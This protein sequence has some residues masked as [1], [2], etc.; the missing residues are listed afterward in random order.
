[1]GFSYLNGKSWAEVTREERFFCQHLFS[2]LK[3]TGTTT[4]LEYVNHKVGISLPVDVAWEPAFE[5]CF[6]R[7]LRH[8]NGRSG[9]LHSAKRTFDLCLFSERAI[10]IIEAK[11]QQSFDGEQ[12][13]SFAAD[14]DEVKALTG[15]ATYVVGLASSAC[16]ATPGC[17][18]VFEGPL[19]TWRDLAALYDEDATLLRAD[20]IYDP[21]ERDTWGRNNQGGHVTG[22]ELLAAFTRGDELLVGRRGGLGGPLLADD[23]SSGSWRTRWYETAS[24]GVPPNGNWFTLGEF[25]RAV[26]EKTD[27]RTPGPQ[28]ATPEPSREPGVPT[29]SELWSSDDEGLWDAALERYWDLL[30]PANVELE[31]E[32]AALTPA[33]VSGLDAAGWLDFLEQRYFRWK[34]T[35]PNRYATTTASLRRQ[36]ARIGPDALLAMRDRILAAEAGP[37]EVALGAACEIGGLGPAG[38]SG[39]LALLFP[40]A[41]GTIDQFVAKALAGVPSLPEREVVSRMSPEGLTIRDGGVLIGIMRRRAAQL[42]AALGVGSW[43]PR[44][45]DMVLWTYGR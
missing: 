29:I 22:E 30:R 32:M 21:V 6:Y 25:A 34:Y 17:E 5:A 10:L 12:L 19:L 37:V 42:N 24:G 33:S 35:A 8:L 41:F 26:G 7:D 16:P 31:H 14:R 45:V 2:L 20:A 11:A 28:M 38:A 15:A 18:Q 1:M 4:F 39:L 27:V 40:Q 23:A 9:P 3:T 36:V 43:T 44:K 13:S